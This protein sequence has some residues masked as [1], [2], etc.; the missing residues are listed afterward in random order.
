MQYPVVY[1]ESMSTVK[2]KEWRF[3]WSYGESMSYVCPVRHAVRHTG[4]EKQEA[5][6]LVAVVLDVKRPVFCIGLYFS[7]L[8]R[9]GLAGVQLQLLSST[10]A[11]TSGAGARVHTV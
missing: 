5:L 1:E 6:S 4:Q 8:L 11:T 2:M 10:N 3:K 9:N 7:C